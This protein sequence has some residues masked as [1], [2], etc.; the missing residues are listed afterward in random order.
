MDHDSAIHHPQQGSKK[1]LLIPIIIFVVIVGL[2]L[3]A[4]KSS[5]MGL[6]GNKPTPTTNNSMEKGG[7]M[8]L[9]STTDSR[10]FPINEEFSLDLRID[11]NSQEVGGYDAVMFYDSN[12]LEFIK[13]DNL[14][15]DFELFT[16]E[17]QVP[18]ETSTKRLTIT[19]IM[20]L[21]KQKPF[22]FNQE[23]VAHIIFR[24]KK[25]GSS[26]I[27]F[28]FTPDE[29]SDSNL[30]LINTE[31]ILSE[32]SHFTIAAGIGHS[33]KVGQAYTD[34][35]S[36]ISVK[37]VKIITPEKTC[38]DCMID[39]ELEITSA[40]GEKQTAIFSNGGFAGKMND[41]KKI[42]QA[43]IEVSNITAQAIE[44][45]IIPE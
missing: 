31:E 18:G 17:S 43:S 5:F 44:V 16:N 22:A 34:P 25:A 45:S 4:K 29:T 33:L 41:S 14:V 21:E 10:S 42:F 28:D 23:P 32:V 24:A 36:K 27:K 38:N 12:L 26:T 37:V 2:I 3:L 19:G 13:A 8:Y 30:V 9:A 20:Q 39:A 40:S 7:K 35:S 6:G 11:T 1:K 15:P